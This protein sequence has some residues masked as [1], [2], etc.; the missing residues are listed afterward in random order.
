VTAGAI[1]FGGWFT[2]SIVRIPGYD[3]LA[4]LLMSVVLFRTTA[5]V[6]AISAGAFALSAGL[7]G[8][9][10]S[11]NPRWRRRYSGLAALGGTAMAVGTFIIVG[12]MIGFGSARS[13]GV[14]GVAGLLAALSAWSTWSM[15]RRSAE[16][17]ETPELGAQ[18]NAD[19]WLANEL[20]RVKTP[21]T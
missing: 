8:R 7:E 1:A 14:L 11:S 16:V 12:P 6:V 9:W 18:R 4:A 3:R 15:R 13:I 5:A 21:V 2:E 20:G 19:E 10:F 17:V